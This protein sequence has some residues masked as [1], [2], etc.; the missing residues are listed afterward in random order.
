MTAKVRAAIYILAAA[1]G[2]AFLIQGSATS[3]Q[4]EAWLKV[5]DSLLNLV[6]IIAPLLA[7][8]FLTPDLKPETRSLDEALNGPGEA[9]EVVG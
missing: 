1:I 2:A 3:E 7:L 6:M 5:L 4:I 8:K 9:D